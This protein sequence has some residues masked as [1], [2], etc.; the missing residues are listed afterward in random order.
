MTEQELREKIEVYRHFLQEGN[1]APQGTDSYITM[2][3]KLQI[4]LMNLQND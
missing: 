4:E 1:K 3:E 2:I